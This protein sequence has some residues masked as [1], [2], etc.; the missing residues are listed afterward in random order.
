MCKYLAFCLAQRDFRHAGEE[1]IFWFNRLNK[2]KFHLVQK[3]IA[4]YKILYCTAFWIHCTK[5]LV[6]QFGCKVTDSFI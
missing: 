1:V 4:I 2:N 6:S 5:G 3:I